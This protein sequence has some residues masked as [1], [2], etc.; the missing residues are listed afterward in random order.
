MTAAPDN[1]CHSTSVFSVA[2]WEATPTRSCHQDGSYYLK[3]KNPQAQP[4][5]FM[6]PISERN[7]HVQ[8]LR[9]F[10]RQVGV[11]LIY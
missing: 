9:L 2:A 3:K 5:K 8:V 11:T 1:I 10:W 6:A 7:L 4:F